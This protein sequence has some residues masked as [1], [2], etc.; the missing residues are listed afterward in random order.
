MTL[1]EQIILHIKNGN[2]QAEQT[3]K[4]AFEKLIEENKQLKADL[5][6]QDAISFIKLFKEELNNKNK[7]NGTQS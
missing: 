7:E 5:A 3:L 4:D 2:K 1:I 6:N